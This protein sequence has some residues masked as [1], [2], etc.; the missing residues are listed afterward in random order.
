MDWV[1]VFDLCWSQN[2]LFAVF[3]DPG[4]QD[5]LIGIIIN[6]V[7]FTRGLFAGTGPCLRGIVSEQV[8]EDRAEHNFLLEC[9]CVLVHHSMVQSWWL[10][11]ST[12][13][14]IL[15]GIRLGVSLSL[16]PAELV[17]A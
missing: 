16:N 15:L 12:M 9:L 14:L 11:R 5:L 8:F 4:I 1:Q 7:R 2:R 10:L 13:R 17:D 3:L 6:R